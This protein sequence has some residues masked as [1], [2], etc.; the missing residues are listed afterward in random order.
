M[1]EAAVLR[2]LR[3]AP[4]WRLLAAD[5]AAPIAAL[6]KAHLL[7]KERKLP[8]SVLVE[9]LGRDLERLR[10]EGW[11]LPQPASAYLAD[12]LSFGWLERSYAGGGEEEYELTTAAIQA[13]RFLQGLA[14]QRAV[15]TES[16]LNVV[17]Q[18]LVQLAEQTETDPEARVER[19]LRERERIDA[20]I[21]A[22]RAGHIETLPDERALERLREVF[23]LADELISDFRRVRDELRGLN[24]ELR[25]R[26][27]DS[28]GSRGEVLE[29]VF[30]GVDLIADSDAG[31][32]F[33][34]FW[35]LLTD[36]REGAELESAL[37]ALMARP[38][39]AGLERSERRWLLGLTRLLLERGGEVHEV[40][41]H[42]ARGLK[43]FVQSQAYREQR[44][45]TRLVK[46]AQRRA[47]QH[48]DRIRPYQSIG[49][50]LQLTGATCRSLAQFR[51]YDPSLDHVDAGIP[52]AEAAEISL[53]GIG[54]LVAH[55]EIDFR[56][57]EA[58]VDSLLEEREQVSIAEVLEVYPAEQGLG[59]IVGYLALGGRCGV[60]SEA[61]DHISWRGLDGAER[62][63]RIPRIYFVRD[64]GSDGEA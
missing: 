33:R 38:F 3:A 34:T 56:T 1:Q 15:A 19:L 13:I 8:A 25:E 57:L 32:S 50:D 28:E 16:R 9:R 58:H 24:R 35:R 18:Q 10:A 21:A 22:I 63:A 7:G 20:E 48:K 41:Q 26:I 12:W 5:L 23:G 54:E 64:D 30:A 37:D 53:E 46:A 27:V 43:Q 4:A 40:M 2:N 31:R 49:T 44:R 62:A 42:F 52:A 6:L 55:S 17:I 59:S 36:P 51:L 11:E 39:V 60:R 45:M 47:L 14:A 61:S 29:A